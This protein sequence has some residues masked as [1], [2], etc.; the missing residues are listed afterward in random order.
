MSWQLRFL[1]LVPLILI[2]SHQVVEV[3]VDESGSLFVLDEV[4]LRN[5]MNVYPNIVHSLSTRNIFD[6]LYIAK[7]NMLFI[8]QKT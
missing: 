5:R 6:H 4:L 3:A 1:I 8:Y 2:E 7:G